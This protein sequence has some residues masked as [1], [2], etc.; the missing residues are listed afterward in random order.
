[1][2]K[3]LFIP[4]ILL[5]LIFFN[6]G[7]TNEQYIVNDNAIQEENINTQENLIE[8]DWL[9]HKNEDFK[10]KF[11]YPANWEVKEYDIDHNLNPIMRLANKEI[12][13][14]LSGEIYIR[15]ETSNSTDIH[16]W[17]NSDTEEKKGK[18]WSQQDYNQVQEDPESVSAAL[19]GEYYQEEIILKNGKKALKQIHSLEGGD[20]IK[21][22]I[23]NSQKVFVISAGSERYYFTNP[24]RRQEIDQGEIYEE[25]HDLIESFEFVSKL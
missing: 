22:L 19:I 18:Y 2:R 13:E 8:E 20:Y 3:Y 7:C 11:E 9:I 4:T 16:Q 14:K 21:V 6:T 1:M 17:L 10:F 25:F 23:P 15:I 12:E 24:E 5:G